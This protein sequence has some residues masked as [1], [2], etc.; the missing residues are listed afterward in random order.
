MVD[1]IIV[2]GGR[3]GEGDIDSSLNENCP[4]G[5]QEAGNTRRYTIKANGKRLG[6]PESP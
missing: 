5:W 3:G 6:N 1:H 4:P 2:H